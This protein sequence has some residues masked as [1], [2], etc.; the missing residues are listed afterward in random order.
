M[1]WFLSGSV[2]RCGIENILLRL[3]FL[4]RARLVLDACMQCSVQRG[5]FCFTP[6]KLIDLVPQ[7]QR[8]RCIRFVQSSTRFEECFAELDCVG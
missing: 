3:F 6:S 5:V 4:D 2:H 7:R 1:I 8:V